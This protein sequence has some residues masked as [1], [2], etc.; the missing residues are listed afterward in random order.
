MTA[1]LRDSTKTTM[2]NLPFFEVED[3][4]RSEARR[5]AMG[6]AVENMGPEADR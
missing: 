6:R 3:I 4:D 2:K 5:L 1:I